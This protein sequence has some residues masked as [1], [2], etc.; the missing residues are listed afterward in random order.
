MLAPVLVPKISDRLSVGLRWN[1]C[2]ILHYVKIAEQ[3]DRNPVVFG[4]LAVAAD[5]DSKLARV[6]PPQHNGCLGADSGQVN[7]SVSGRIDGP[8]QAIGFLHKQGCVRP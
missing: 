6:T 8:K 7:R 1:A 5:H 3:W 2:E 4:D